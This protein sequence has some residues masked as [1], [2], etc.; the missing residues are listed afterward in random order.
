[1]QKNQEK[2]FE[3]D[4]EERRR[5]QNIKSKR[6]QNLIKKAQELASIASLYVTVV[7]YDPALNVLQEFFSSADFTLENI[8]EHE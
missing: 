2:A 3:N 5:I 7:V 4:P 8:M 6:K 1:M